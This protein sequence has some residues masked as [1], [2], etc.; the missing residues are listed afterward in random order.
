MNPDLQPCF[1]KLKKMPFQGENTMV[2]GD[3]AVA[4][5]DEYLG[6]VEDYNLTARYVQFQI[7]WRFLGIISDLRFLYGFLKPYGSGYVFLSGFH[8][9]SLTETVRGCVSLKK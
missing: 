6:H 1:S 5:M 9:F 7:S 3:V 2:G 8:T 4:Y